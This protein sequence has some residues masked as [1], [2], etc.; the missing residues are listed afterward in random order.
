MAALPNKIVSS[1]G[2][3]SSLIFVF[4]NKTRI[5]IQTSAPLPN[6]QLYWGGWG[7]GGTG[8]GR[9]AY[10][11]ALCGVLGDGLLGADNL[12]GFMIPARSAGRPRKGLGLVFICS[13]TILV[14]TPMRGAN[15]KTDVSH[16]I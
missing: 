11:R 15:A 13:T 3:Q 4:L 10:T 5:Y 14:Q 12:C 16:V 9:R 7:V 6:R 1:I 8:D 2:K